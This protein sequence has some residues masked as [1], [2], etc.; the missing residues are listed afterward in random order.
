MNG[1]KNPDPGSAADAARRFRA[2]ALS[3][4]SGWWDTFKTVAWA[5]TIAVAVRTFA[6]EPFHIPSGSMAPTL[7]IGDFLFVSKAS[8]GYSRYSL[9]FGAGLIDGRI[10][11]DPPERGDI[12]VFRKPSDPGVD[13][14]KRLI[15]LPGDRIQMRGG[16]LHLNG[17]PVERRRIEDYIYTD[18]RN[19]RYAARQY[20]ETLPNGTSYRTLDVNENGYGDDT[21][22]YVVPEGHFFAM[23]DN[24]DNSQDSRVLSEVGYV[25]R[26]NLVGRAEIMFISVDGRFWEFWNWRLGRFFNPL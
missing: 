22:V 17:E 23:G 25:P 5:I 12:A 15:G 10:W 21:R 4:W 11:Y 8:Y 20:V 1:A 3:W 24:R 6:Y 26:E 19:R 13:Y 16:V 9:P 14:I 7:L 18:R 2:W